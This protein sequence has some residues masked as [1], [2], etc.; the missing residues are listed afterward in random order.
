MSKKQAIVIS[1]EFFAIHPSLQIITMN[2]LNTNAPDINKQLHE[3]TELISLPEVYLKIRQLMA[4]DDSDIADFAEIVRL[5]PNL[6]LAV[7]KMV[8]S[9]FF[10]F[11]RKIENV[12]Q[13]TNMIGIGQLHIIVLGLSAI[14]ALNCPN[15]LIPLK[16]FWRSSLFTGVLA[17]L[18]AQRQ[19]IPNSE[20]LFI[21]GLLHEIGHLVLYTKLPELTEHTI[22]LAENDNLPIHEAESQVFGCHYGD[23]G[24]LLLAQWG[25]PDEYQMA[26]RHQP[27]PEVKNPCAEAVGLLHLAHGYA[28][29]HVGLIESAD[30][31]INPI[32][33]ETKQ[34]TPKD[35]ECELDAART[36][37]SDMERIISC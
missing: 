15:K 21:Q 5:D 32:A 9:A 22:G 36:I 12:L 7:L 19:K 34:L 30:M 23:V 17:Q 37:T 18:L 10:G 29:Q 8:N 25:L 24:A 6:S 16:T 28:Q 27:T 2:V 13:A 35:V 33:W 31:A 14:S 20:T 11:S 26:I 3:V 4:D 1:S